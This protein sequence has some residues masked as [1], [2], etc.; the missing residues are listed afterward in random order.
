M[1]LEDVKWAIDSGDKEEARSLLQDI[2]RDNPSADA[3][4]LAAR[5]A[6]NEQDTFNALK[7]ALEFDPDHAEAS[8]LYERMKILFPEEELTA[9]PSALEPRTQ[10]PASSSP[11]PSTTATSR[12]QSGGETPFGSNIPT[13]SLESQEVPLRFD[14][15]TSTPSSGGAGDGV[16]E[17]LWDCRRCG[18]QGLLGKTHRHCPN[19]GAPQDPDWRY[20]P[21]DDKKVAVK[22]HVF[23]GVDVTCP[24]CG[25]LNTGDANFCGTCGAPL[26]SAETVSLHGKRDNAG[27][28]AFGT[29]DLHSRI[30]ARLDADARGESYLQAQKAP[31]KKRNRFVIGGILTVLVAVVAFILVAVFWTREE[32]VVVSGFRWERTIEVEELRAVTGSVVCDRMPSAAYSVTR[33]REQIDTRQV[34]DGQT[35][36]N[37]QVDQGDGTFRQRQECETN[38][39]SEPVYGDVCYYTID[40]WQ[41]DRTERA[42]GDKTQSIIWPEVNLSCT[43]NRLGCEREG[44]RD[45]NYIIIFDMDAEKV[46]CEVGPDLWQQTGIEQVF[47]VKVGVVGGGARCDSLESA[48]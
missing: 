33:R 44:D 48:Q 27:S 43:G 38:Y 39:R 15:G 14:G 25:S 46:E 10:S 20:F 24:N 35:C 34:P 19:C 12:R 3:W 32:A 18:T 11:S 21:S 17:M 7:K 5:V 41:N 31:S 42:S 45:E 1:S 2:L 22:D 9:A 4:M 23:V 40:Q 36:R 37:V 8:Q 13:S 26:E 6:D 30:N 47:T 28:A 29:E 16:Y